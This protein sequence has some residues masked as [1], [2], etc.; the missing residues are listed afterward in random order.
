MR[1]VGCIANLRR[2]VFWGRGHGFGG[3]G[4]FGSFWFVFNGFAA[5]AGMRG[6]SHDRDAEEDREKMGNFNA[7]Q[8]VACCRQGRICG[9]FCVP[10]NSR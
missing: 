5:I 9:Q 7:Q 1:V 6:T 8:V 3:F 4:G 2:S 10:C